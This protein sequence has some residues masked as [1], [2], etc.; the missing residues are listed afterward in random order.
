MNKFSIIVLI[1]FLIDLPF[2]YLDCWALLF[3][4]LWAFLI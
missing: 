2:Y 3:V 4:F 1:L